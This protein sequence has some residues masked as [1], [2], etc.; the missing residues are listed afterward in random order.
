MVAGTVETAIARALTGNPTAMGPR[1]LMSALK[2]AVRRLFLVSALM[3]RVKDR[4]TPSS[5]D[6]R[7]RGA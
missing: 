5:C 7:K 3:H 1:R 6:L 4:P 2:R